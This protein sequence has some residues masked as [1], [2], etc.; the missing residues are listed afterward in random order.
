M[1]LETE[2]RVIPYEKIDAGVSMSVDGALL[3]M[4]ERDIED[5]KKVGP[6]LRVYSFAHPTVVMGYNQKIDGRFDFDLA[7]KKGVKLTVRDSGGG[8]MY[9]S[10]DDVH[11]SFI[12]PEEIGI[13]LI[14][15]YH[16]INSRISE[17]LR[18][19]GY[20]TLLGR[21]SIRI[22]NGGEKL[23]VG[24]AI[25]K[26]KK[27]NVYL[28]QGGILVDNYDG[29][30]F[31]LLEARPDEIERWEKQVASLRDYK[32]IDPSKIP[33]VI[34]SHFE[35]H[36][37]RPLTK[38]E[39]SYAELLNKRRYSNNGVILSGTKEGDICLIAGARSD[40]NKEERKDE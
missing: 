6:I 39:R 9:F 14:E 37:A 3:D 1:N 29:E 17:A 23:I 36:Y 27:N 11:F 5:G 15:Q 32:D 22:K 34:F 31:R 10:T 8:H 25:R 4:M 28:H 13:R 40:K 12:S 7:K 38:E 16:Q 33:E 21:T 2:L 24:T 20:N 30:I 18:E 19:L 26:K 35:N